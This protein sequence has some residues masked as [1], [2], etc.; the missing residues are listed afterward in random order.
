MPQACS[1]E[2]GGAVSS[3]ACDLAIAAPS[4]TASAATRNRKRIDFIKSLT[5]EDRFHPGTWAVL[6]TLIRTRLPRKC[7]KK[8]VNPSKVLSKRKAILQQSRLSKV[9][10]ILYR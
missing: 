8:S 2:G 6:R 7:G 3:A 4:I 5:P 10:T 9:V 1:C